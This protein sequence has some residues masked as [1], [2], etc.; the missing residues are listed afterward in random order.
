MLRYVVESQELCSG[1]GWVDDMGM[2]EELGHKKFWSPR[3]A[4]TGFRT[5]PD[6]AMVPDSANQNATK[7]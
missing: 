6:S 2:S 3:E 1:V 5:A 7:R 4:K